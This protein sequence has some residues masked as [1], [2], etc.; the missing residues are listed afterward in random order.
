M[1]TQTAPQTIPVPDNFPVVF[2]DGEER[3]FWE[4]DRMHFPG[5]MTP[6]EA[7]LAPERIATGMTYAM[8]HYEMPMS[9]FR[10]RV[11]HGYVYNAPVPI[12]APPEEMEELGRRTEAKLMPAVQGI[13]QLWNDEL[14]PE[15]KDHL[16]AMEAIDLEHSTLPELVADLDNA[17]FH[18]ERLWQLHFLAVHPAYLAVS[19]FDEFYRDLMGTEDAF[20]SYRLL[21]GLENKTVEMGK[22]LWRLSR[23]AQESPEVRK[24]LETVAAADVR[25]K[26]AETPAGTAFLAELSDYLDRYGHR[27]S[28]WGIGGP[29]F[30]ED[31]TPVINNLKEYVGLPDEADPARELAR[32]SEEREQAIAEIRELLTNYPAPVAG[33]FEGMLHSA[34]IGLVVTEDHGFYIDF[35]G[36]DL[37]RQLLMAIGRRLVEA[38]V[39]ESADDVLMLEL[40][41]IRAPGADARPLVAE[42]RAEL[43]AYADVTPPPVLGTLPPGPPPENPV[44]RAMMK[45]FGTP[46]APPEDDGTLRGSARAC[47]GF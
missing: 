43:A 25:A 4:Q 7:A 5:Q 40:D 45:F 27:S 33:Q 13:E 18:L 6:L 35:Y 46:A 9:E 36:L 11:I 10:S 3:L 23:V 38:D 47:S 1:T 14:L 2:Q 30:I 16:A 42:R 29:S 24:V 31:P 41:E 28:I 19:E 12:I 34:Q 44:V 39:I 17:E 8:R 22:E 15:I 37:I 26:L 32:M 20:A 21:Q